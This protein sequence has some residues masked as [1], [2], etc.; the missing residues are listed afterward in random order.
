[1]VKCKICNK[2]VYPMDPQINLDGS[3]FH[4]ICAKCHDCHCQITLSNFV[5][6]ETEAE[7]LLLCKT[8]HLKR[9]HEQG[10]YLGAEKF[11]KAADRDIAALAKD[12]SLVPPAKT[13]TPA[14]PVSSAEPALT[15]SSQQ[16]LSEEEQK[17][18]AGAVKR[19]LDMRKSQISPPPQE[20]VSPLK[21]SVAA[22]ELPS[23]PVK[24]ISRRLSTSTDLDVDK[25][26][27]PKQAVG[28]GELPS[29]PVREISKRLSVKS[30]KEMSN[31]RKPQ[32]SLTDLVPDLDTEDSA[33]SGVPEMPPPPIPSVELS[34]PSSDQ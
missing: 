3:I 29:V 2:S 22:E 8:H 27:P 4:K 25:G 6:H 1:M 16:H 17:A 21:Q 14:Q 19:N 26:S 33:S 11:K 7:V 24:E 13:N 15:A 5:K 32:V 31:E 12:P 20:V 34:E 23:V 9:F 30:D 10:S 18:T 28:A